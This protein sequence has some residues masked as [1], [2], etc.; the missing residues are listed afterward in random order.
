MWPPIPLPCGWLMYGTFFHFKTTDKF[1]ADDCWYSSRPSAAL[2][3]YLSQSGFWPGWMV[4]HHPLREVHKKSFS[5]FIVGP[6]T[7]R[8]HLCF[9]SAWLLRAMSWHDA[10]RLMPYTLVADRPLSNSAIF[11]HRLIK[12][13]LHISFPSWNRRKSCGIRTD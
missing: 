9:H 12:M 11:S 6:F 13:L 10:K 1:F 2:Y 3:F 5:I 4:P 7:K 8:V